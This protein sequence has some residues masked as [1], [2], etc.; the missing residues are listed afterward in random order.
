MGDS[1]SPGARRSQ[2]LPNRLNFAPGDQVNV[3]V[4]AD[5]SRIL[6][7]LKYSFSRH[8][9]TRGELCEYCIIEKV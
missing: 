2:E 5:K 7:L 4:A 6:D 1:G 8:A 9:F 3:F